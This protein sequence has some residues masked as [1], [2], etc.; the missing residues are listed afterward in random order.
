M[1]SDQPSAHF[2]GTGATPLAGVGTVRWYE[3]GGDLSLG[4]PPAEPETDATVERE[5]FETAREQARTELETERERTAEAIG[6]EEAAV[7]EAH[8]QF[9]DDPQIVERVEEAIEGGLPAE[10]AVRD[11][12]ADPIAQFEGME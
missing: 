8:R 3:P 1:S 12:F 9:V 4:E 6:E 10:F 5:R 2:E 7:F 11:A